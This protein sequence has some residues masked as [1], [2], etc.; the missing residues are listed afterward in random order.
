MFG[1]TIVTIGLL[2][3]SSLAA[4]AQA[5]V[6]LGV[7]EEV[8]TSRQAPAQAVRVLFQSD[9]QDWRPLATDCPD[10]DCSR[11]MVA[12]PDREAVW[13]ISSEGQNL[14]QVRSRITAEFDLNAALGR[15]MLVAQTSLPAL[16]S[17]HYGGGDEPAFRPLVATSR[18]Y[19]SDPDEWKPS[20]VSSD[21]GT[22]VR[23]AF[24][25]EYPQA[26]N[27]T[28]GQS[29]AYRDSDITISG[30]YGSK[31][32]W[33]LVEVNLEACANTEDGDK[34]LHSQWFAVNGANEAEYIGE[35]IE[36]VGSGD[37]DNDGS[38]ELVFSITRENRSGYELFYDDFSKR[39]TFLYT[40]H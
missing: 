16:R 37:Y 40:Y 5:P 17:A 32:Y 39:A 6:L 4:H 10:Y 34:A 1:R 21:I 28:S 18:N 2:L 15:Q 11:P 23:K 12:R 13:T 20:S 36:L 9:G 33:H 24:R 38:S 7:L 8:T 30:A 22:A 31:F 35:G 26:H 25:A 3:G 19:V 27:C 29:Y 14:G